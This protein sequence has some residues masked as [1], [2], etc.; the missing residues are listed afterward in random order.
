MV[1]GQFATI[2][3]NA[4]DIHSLEPSLF[5]ELAVR[6]QY[7]KNTLES[8]F[9]ASIVRFRR[10]NRNKK[11]R[12]H[13]LVWLESANDNCWLKVTAGTTVTVLAD[14]FSVAVFELV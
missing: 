4:I 8:V 1:Q 6:N 2:V 9:Q 14:K 10:E 13:D 12:F 7:L 11:S 3:G 5:V